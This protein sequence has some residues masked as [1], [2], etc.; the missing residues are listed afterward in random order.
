MLQL[1]NTR[2]GAGVGWGALGD[3]DGDTQSHDD[4]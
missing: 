1:T 2:E 4:G 3:D